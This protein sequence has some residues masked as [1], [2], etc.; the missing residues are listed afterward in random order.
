MSDNANLN[1]IW[2]ISILLLIIIILSGVKICKTPFDPPTIFVDKP[3]KYVSEP[4][5]DTDP[6]PTTD[7]STSIRN[8]AKDKYEKTLAQ[9][10]ELSKQNS[11]MGILSRQIDALENKIKVLQQL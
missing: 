9:T 3:Y 6:S 4:F 7:F 8:L 1:I 10:I 2:V 5:G 11:K